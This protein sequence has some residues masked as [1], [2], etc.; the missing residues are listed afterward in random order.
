MWTNLAEIVYE[1]SIHKLSDKLFT[2]FTIYGHKA[3]KL[4]NIDNY[5]IDAIVAR[6]C[7]TV[8]LGKSVMLGLH[9]ITYH[10]N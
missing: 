1:Y 3:F 5:A 8:N 4:R 6:I 9:L 10:I 2:L 7:L